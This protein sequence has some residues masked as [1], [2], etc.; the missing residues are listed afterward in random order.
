MKN[1]S[2]V[3]VF[4][5]LVIFLYSCEKYKKFEFSG[6]NLTALRDGPAEI[7]QEP[8]LKI[9]LE[10]KLQA[11]NGLADFTVVKDNEVFDQIVFTDEISSDYLFEY[12]IPSDEENGTEHF[13]S[14]LLK[15][16]TGREAN[17]DLKVTA[18]ATFSE[19]TEE[20]NG[21][22][23]IRVKGKLNNS[24]HFSANN[25]YLIDSIFS[26]ENNSTLTVEKGSTV[27]FKTYESTYTSKLFITQGSKLIAEGSAEEPIVFTS[28]KLL[29]NQEPSSKDW[30]GITI[31][32]KAPTNEGDIA[33]TDGFRYGGRSTNDNSGILKY[34]RIEYVGDQDGTYSNALNL[35]GVGSRTII[36]HVEVF[37]NDNIAFRLKGGNV[38]LKYIA[39]IGH[40]G[41]GVWAE[42][43]WQGKGQFWILQTDVP[44]TLTPVNFWNQARSIE[45]RNNQDQFLLTPRTQFEISNVT[46]IGNG[47]Q[48]DIQNGTRR[49]VRIRR[50]AVGMIQNMLVTEFPDDGVRVE[51]LDLTELKTTMVL[52]HVRSFNNQSNY[53]KDA[54]IFFS[55]SDLDV[56]DQPSAGITLDNFVGSER[57][58]FDPAQQGSFFSSAP[59]IGAV[60]SDESDWTR[61][62]NWFKDLNGII[63]K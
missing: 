1:L 40:G 46:L 5:L 19:I 39:A 45:M 28:D 42:Y 23:V 18:K 9:D 51:D 52:D 62:G 50:G 20:V 27:Y 44:A 13:F 32:G 61:D 25:T 22:E 55:D 59:Y 11:A 16:Q 24:Y 8:G 7:I 48:E 6:P 2:Y 30:G 29:L 14:F 31:L 37:R 26:V 15:D 33:L 10:F 53:S 12:T 63:R 34:V 35:F 58:S 43:G 56:T 60:E 54:Q 36:D 4:S 49:G 47:F 38:N 21:T 3:F 41:Y 57:S 17:Y